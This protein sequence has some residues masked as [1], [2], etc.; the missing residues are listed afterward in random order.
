MAV[1]L[2]AEHIKKS[3][4]LKKLITDATLYI[5]EHE[6]IGVVGIN[7][8][9]KS[10]LLKLLCGMEEPDDGTIMRRSGLRVSY[11]PQMPDY[12]EKRTAVGQ[13]LKAL[14]RTWAHRTSTRRDRCSRSWA[15]R[16]LMRTCARSPA[17]RKSAS[18]W[19]RR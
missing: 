5:G 9:G 3:F 12:S 6:R 7:G 16:I 1:I 19:R 18:H 2:S 15:S 17:G 10:T 13:V 4:T 11:L 14:R 8:T